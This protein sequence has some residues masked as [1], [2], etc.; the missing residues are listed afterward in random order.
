MKYLIFVLACA[1]VMSGDVCAM[2]L[3]TMTRSGAGAGVFQ[4]YY[5]AHK[6]LHQ[7]WRVYNGDTSESLSP[8]AD[9]IIAELERRTR[10]LM[11][12]P[13]ANDLAKT[14]QQLQ[15]ENARLGALLTWEQE[16]G[17]RSNKNDDQWVQSARAP[18]PA[19]ES[20]RSNDVH[21]GL[22]PGVPSEEPQSDAEQ[23][24]PGVYGE[25]VDSDLEQ[26]SLQLEAAQ[27]EAAQAQ[28]APPPVPQ[29]PPLEVQRNESNPVIFYAP[30]EPAVPP[31]VV[32]CRT[33]A[34]CAYSSLVLTPDRA[35]LPP[36]ISGSV[37][38]L[39]QEPIPAIYQTHP[40]YP[41]PHSS[42]YQTSCAT[43]VQRSFSDPP[44]PQVHPSPKKKRSRL[45]WKSLSGR[46][47][48][49]KK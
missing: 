12:T 3:E 24:E 4:A 20:Q 28:E 44:Q 49:D 9:G 1:S 38:I 43:R 16:Y 7:C 46:K 15:N 27:V 19:P 35:T 22:M 33:A 17:F 25:N 31:A 5:W 39:V 45:H 14:V 34:G 2:D 29:W 32:A 23:C 36:P 48:K 40:P 11:L 37:P 10:M 47:K 42:S 8:E 41:S 30:A 13:E 6:N 26:W 21:Y 18:E